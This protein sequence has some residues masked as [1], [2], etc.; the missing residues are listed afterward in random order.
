VTIL[1]KKWKE[2]REINETRTL[3]VSGSGGGLYLFLPKTFCETYEINGGDQI[4]VSLRALF[5]RDYVTEGSG[6]DPGASASESEI[7]EGELTDKSKPKKGGDV[8]GKRQ[9]GA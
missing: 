1:I 5:K 7:Q 3:A 8:R 6:P 9:K 2:A 4:K